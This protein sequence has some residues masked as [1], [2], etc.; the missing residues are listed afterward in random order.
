MI[1]AIE[2]SFNGIKYRSRLEARWAMAFYL[3]GVDFLYEYE[4]FNIDDHTW[5]LPDFYLPA[6][7]IWVEVKGAKPTI[8]EINKC[9]S[10]AD[11]RKEP[12]VIVYGS[13]V[14]CEY[15]GYPDGNKMAV[16]GHASNLSI[17]GECNKIKPF[18]SCFFYGSVYRNIDSMVD[19]HLIPN[20]INCNPFN[21][22]SNS[23]LEIVQ[24]DCEYQTKKYGKLITYTRNLCVHSEIIRFNEILNI[25]IET[26]TQSLVLA[27]SYRF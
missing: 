14:D 25:D 10:I 1:K 4:G 3:M 24:K 9:H 18:D 7:G 13:M 12:F 6:I 5:Y 16:Y 20:G 21:G 19:C 2:T 17:T 27:Q 8:E 26:Y 22:S 15:T 23:Y 11:F